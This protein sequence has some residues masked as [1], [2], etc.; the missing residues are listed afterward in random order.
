MIV[1]H[2]FHVEL[3]LAVAKALL[4]FASTDKT[5]PHLGV[6][7]DGEA[8]GSTDGHAAVMFDAGWTAVDSAKPSNHSGRVWS[9]VHVETAVKVARAHKQATVALNYADL[10]PDGVFPPL[11]RV[12]PEPGID[13][14][15]PIGFDPALVGQLEPVCKACECKGAKLTT[16][17]A[18]LDPLGFT[19]EGPTGLRARAAVMPMRV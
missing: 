8:I 9:R 2:P 3:S 15:K 16:L 6:G 7:I 1:Y 19:V 12:M 11:S 17:G 13:A 10:L 4:A 5:R 14:S 18:P